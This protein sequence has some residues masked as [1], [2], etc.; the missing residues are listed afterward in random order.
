MDLDCTAPF[1]YCPDAVADADAL[2]ATVCAE[3]RWTDQMRAR[4]TASMGRPYNYAGASYP[5]SSWH[6]AVWALAEHL[7]PAIGFVP[8]NCLLNAYPTGD[9]TMG[10]HADDVDI[11]EAGTG[12]AIV[13]LGA[14]RTLSL[15]H[16]TPPDFVYERIRLAPGSL[17]WM[18]AGLQAT[19]KHS[20]RREPEAGARISLTFRR[21]VRDSPIV[22]RRPWGA[23]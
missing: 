6:P 12:I 13:S 7:A 16:G 18:S 22:E 11:L 19:H 1:G 10:W 5:E 2:F 17:F 4:R 8:T 14:S 21:I 15:R 23:E 20:I 3:A 9:H